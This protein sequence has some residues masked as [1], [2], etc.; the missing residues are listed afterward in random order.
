MMNIA[1]K[2]TLY[3]KIHQYIKNENKNKKYNL[4]QFW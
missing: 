3:E 4:N 2:L 1:I